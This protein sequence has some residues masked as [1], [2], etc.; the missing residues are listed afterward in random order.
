MTHKVWS[1][2]YAGGLSILEGVIHPGALIP[3]HTHTREDECMFVIEGELTF[4]VGG[5]VAGIGPGRLP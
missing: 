1:E 4:D 2:W 5:T 3:P